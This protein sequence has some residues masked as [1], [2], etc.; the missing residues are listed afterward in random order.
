MYFGIFLLQVMRARRHAR[1]AD[2]VMLSR[3][4]EAH[5]NTFSY[6]P[7]NLKYQS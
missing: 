4:V 7:Q 6:I 2:T 3:M 5:T 1:T